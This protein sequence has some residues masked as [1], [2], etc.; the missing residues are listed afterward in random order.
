[1][2]LEVVGKEG[3]EA[4]GAYRAKS[5]LCAAARG[6]LSRRNNIGESSIY[7]L[8]NSTVNAMS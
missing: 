5:T 6:V 4:A 1:M 2:V 7:L 8:F 3:R